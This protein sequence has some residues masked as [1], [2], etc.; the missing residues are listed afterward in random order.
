MDI[1]LYLLM[2]RMRA[3]CAADQQTIIT[4]KKGAYSVADRQ[5]HNAFCVV[6]DLV[7]G[8]NMETSREQSSDDNN[9]E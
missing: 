5:D 9:H 3:I 6:I 7:P 1:P 8:E 2:R 4:Q